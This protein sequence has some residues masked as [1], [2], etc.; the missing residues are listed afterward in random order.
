MMLKNLAL[1]Q[2]V[3]D[4]FKLQSEPI[5]EDIGLIATIPIEPY[6]NIV[7]WLDNTG[8]VYTTPTD[9]DFYLTN[10][11]ISMSK[12][13]GNTGALLRLDITLEDGTAT[14]LMF[15]TSE[16]AI[17]HQGQIVENYQKGIK[18]K[19]NTAITLTASGTF[20]ISHANIKGYTTDN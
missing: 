7:K 19:R 16:T 10:A 5:D 4:I 9:K 8:T 18:L 11:F 6:I 2:R 12:N 13:A 3:K 17:V 14:R 20:A 15:I 1:M